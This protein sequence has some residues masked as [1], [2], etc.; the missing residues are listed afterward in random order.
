MDGRWFLLSGVLT[1][2][3]FERCLS[4][5]KGSCEYI[6]LPSFLAR[7]YTAR[8]REVRVPLFLWSADLIG[9]WCLSLQKSSCGYIKLSASPGGGIQGECVVMGEDVG[10]LP[11]E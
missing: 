8:R 1:Q 9:I 10:D 3:N 11:L 6:K 2:K 7:E 5:Q 4:L